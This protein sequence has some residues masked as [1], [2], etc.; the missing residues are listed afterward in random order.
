MAGDDPGVADD[1]SGPLT[2]PAR[3]PILLDVQVQHRLRTAGRWMSSRAWSRAGA[4]AQVLATG[5]P[6]RIMAR[7]SRFALFAGGS[8]LIGAAVAVMLWNQLGP[9]PLDVF[10]GAVRSRTGLPLTLA[11]WSTVFS[12]LGVAWLLG[13]RPGWGSVAGPVVVGPVMQLVLAQLDE[14][15]PPSTLVFRIVVQLVAIAAVGIGAGA[16]IASGLGA[17]SGELLAAAASDRSGHSEPRVRVAFE[18]SW[19]VL[20]VALGGPI[21]LGTV[22]VALSIGP[23]VASG[24]RLVDA[25]M[26]YSRR[27]L[28]LAAVRV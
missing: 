18:L 28:S 23:A 27:R 17:G 5:T 21:G 22:I 26:A 6:R 14:V 12:L 9:G 25:A 15:P 4:V 10:I 3:R 19:L 20:G 16:T 1:T 13:R 11:V 7:T 2:S 24:Y 8:V